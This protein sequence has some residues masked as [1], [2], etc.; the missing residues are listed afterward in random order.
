MA[1]GGGQIADKLDVVHA[2]GPA[3][4]SSA[5][6]DWISLKNARSV[7]IVVVALNGST[8]TGSAVGLS[9]ASDV[10]GTGAKT[11]AFT[12]YFANVTPATSSVPT[13]ATAVSNTFTTAT[14]NSATLVYRIPI[15]PST[16]DV[17]NGFDCL[18][19]TLGNAAN[20]SVV[21]FYLVEGAY[22]GKVT[23]GVNHVVD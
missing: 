17:A 4:P 19:V 11:L 10:S 2:F 16:L 22:A 13:A 6:P 18:R 14:T 1:T 7:E 12:N 20:T 8:V 15:D 23:A 5:A 3:T 21:A 9:Q